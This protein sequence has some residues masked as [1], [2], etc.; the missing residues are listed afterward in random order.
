[1]ADDRR[2]AADAA[3]IP[4]YVGPQQPLSS[5]ERHL[6]VIGDRPDAAIGRNVVA[7]AVRAKPGPDLF[8]RHELHRCAQGVTGGS[9]KQ[10][11]KNPVSCR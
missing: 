6:G 8:Q 5:E 2:D 11:A 7:D 9:P 4:A 3:Q 10:A 1:M